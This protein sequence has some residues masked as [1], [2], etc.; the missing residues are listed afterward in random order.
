MVNRSKRKRVFY[1]SIYI[2]ISLWGDRRRIPTEEKAK[3]IAAA[4]GAAFI[5]IPCHAS[6]FSPAWF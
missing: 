3:V 4:L 6:Y 2:I 5:P 1:W